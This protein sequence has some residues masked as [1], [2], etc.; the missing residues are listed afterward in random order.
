MGL[1]GTCSLTSCRYS[2]I[3]YGP[4]ISGIIHRARGNLLQQPSHDLTAS[5]LGQRVA[6]LC[7]VRSR[8][9]PD[10]LAQASKAIGN[11][12]IMGL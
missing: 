5:R 6:P 12:T 7:R 2:G 1:W 4:G 3:G 11:S 8:A 10:L 9:G